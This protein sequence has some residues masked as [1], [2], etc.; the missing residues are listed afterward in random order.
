M[1]NKT[2]GRLNINTINVDPRVQRPLDTGRV[3]KIAGTFSPNYLGTVTVSERPDGTFIALDGQT[4]TA[5]ARLAGYKGDVDAVIFTGLTLAEEAATFL[6]LNDT[7]Q[8]SAIDKFL[9]RVTENDPVATE[10]SRVLGHHGWHVAAGGSEGSFAA[11]N[12]IEKAWNRAGANSV[13]AVDRIMKT[14]TES[15]GHNKY[16]VNASIVGGMDEFFTRYGSDAQRHKLVKGLQ[17]VQPRQ[18]IG[19]AKTLQEVRRGSMTNAM[20]NVLHGLHNKG[21]RKGQLPEWR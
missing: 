2:I 10:L 19:H 14:I 11:V 13:F 7:K 5:A 20:G 18:L 15:W 8:V 16:G 4:R 3:E 1:T 21:L 6:R 17:M 9:V 12:A